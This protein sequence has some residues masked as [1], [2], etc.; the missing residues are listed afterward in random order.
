[1]ALNTFTPQVS[2]GIVG[3]NVPVYADAKCTQ[4][5]SV[6]DTSGNALKGNA[7]VIPDNAIPPVFQCALSTVYFRTSHGLIVSLT[8]AGA[9]AVTSTSGGNLPNAAFSVV[10]I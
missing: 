8:T 4:R 10:G 2:L 1:M 6:F 7:I 3:G 5:A 9:S